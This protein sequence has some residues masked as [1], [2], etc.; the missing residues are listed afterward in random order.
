MT[1]DWPLPPEGVRFL[2]PGWLAKQLARH[3][4]SEAL[5]PLAMGYYPR[6]RGHRMA[7]E[8]HDNYL[9]IY[10]VDGAGQ[11]DCGERRYRIGSGDVMLLPKGVAHRYAADPEQ[12]W[13][14]YWLHFNGRLAEALCQHCG[15]SAPRFHIGVQPRVVRIF[16]GLSELRRGAYQL[17]EFIQGC[18]QI[19]ALLSYLALLVRQGQP[20]SGGNLDWARVRATMQEHIHGQL[21]L[22]MLAASVNVSKYHFIKKF[23]AWSGQSPIQYFIHMKVQRACYLLDSTTMS[24]KEV[25]SALG[26]DDV[27]YF[28]RQ[29]KKVV[30][31]APSSYRHHRGALLAP[32]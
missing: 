8:Q 11:L 21:S 14:I 25:A 20:D 13:T 16:D 18:H 1:S 23:K 6:A 32:Q 7:R 19:Q 15:L 27:Y 24:V 26:Y 10:C 5:Y 30:G 17:T 2:T 3:P 4:L 28:S 22:D 9:M 29:F 12:P 31:L